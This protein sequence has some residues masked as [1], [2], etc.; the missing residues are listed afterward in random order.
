MRFTYDPEVD[1]LMIYLQEISEGQ[2]VG[3]TVK[4]NDV[5]LIDLDHKG[6]PIDI[7]ILDASSRYE[8][9]TLSN[10]D[11]NLALL[12]LSEAAERAG[13]SANTLKLQV[14]NGRLKAKKVGRNWV[15]TEAWLRDYLISRRYNAK[16]QI[17]A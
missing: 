4:V 6:N 15:T 11:I 1:V 2:T 10:F 12:S 13:L 3:R 8:A 5:M 14:H 17:T 7:E 16:S 9:E